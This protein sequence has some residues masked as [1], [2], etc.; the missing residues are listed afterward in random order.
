VAQFVGRSNLIP[1]TFHD[2]GTGPV[3]IIAGAAFPRLGAA[4]AGQAR[5]ALRFEAIR[6]SPAGEGAS[7]LSG[8]IEDVLFL[9]TN[10]EVNVRCEGLS[11]IASVPAARTGSLARGQAVNLTMDLSTA[12]VFHG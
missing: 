3:A 11:I 6:L 10:L 12:R 7:D 5:L 2:S 1:V 8:V 9:G 4:R